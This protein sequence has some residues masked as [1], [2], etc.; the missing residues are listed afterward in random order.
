[1]LPV[2]AAPPLVAVTAALAAIVPVHAGSFHEALWGA[3]L[4]TFLA[5]ITTY[6]FRRM[7]EVIEE[8]GRT[9]EKLAVAAVSAERLRFSRDLHDRGLRD[10]GGQG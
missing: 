6:G 1:M 7:G 4:T 5:G 10:D 2:R 8:L 3:A 9:R